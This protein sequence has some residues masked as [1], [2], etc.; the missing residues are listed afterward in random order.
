MK[1]ELHPNFKRAYKSRI[2]KNS[3][4]SKQTAK[5]IETFRKNPTHPTLHNHPLKGKRKGFRSFSISGDIRIV[6]YQEF[7]NT[8][9]FIDI[10][11]NNQVY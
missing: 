6:F 9:V 1:I 11:T 7:D 2:A 5:R 8:V 3:K 4:L 10:G